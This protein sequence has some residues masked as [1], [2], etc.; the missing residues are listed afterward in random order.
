MAFKPI[1]IKDA[2]LILGV[3]ATGTNFAIQLTSITLTPDV[4]TERIKTAKPAGRYSS[5]DDPEWSLDLGY[6]YGYDD[7]TADEALAAY[8]LDHTGEQVPFTFRPISGASGAPEISGTVTLLAG[9]I[10]GDQGAFS[11]Q[12]VSLP[13]EGQPTIGAVAP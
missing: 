8:L 6:V 1:V 9:A 13:V 5:V 2:D 4:A 7:T 11:T 10:G 12:T 3:V